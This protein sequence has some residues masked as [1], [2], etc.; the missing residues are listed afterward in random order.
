LKELRILNKVLWI[1]ILV[2]LLLLG[3]CAYKQYAETGSSQ[4]VSQQG[5]DEINQELEQ[6]EEEQ[7]ETESG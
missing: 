5:L 6:V 1:I 3:V 7:K 4:A 2:L